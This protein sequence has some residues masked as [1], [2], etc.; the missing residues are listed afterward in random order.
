V[1]WNYPIAKIMI[2]AKEIKMQKGL[3]GTMNREAGGEA[4]ADTEVAVEIE[5][6]IEIGLVEMIAEAEVEVRGAIAAP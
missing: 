2:V 3:Q 6:E 1:K 5:T 4:E